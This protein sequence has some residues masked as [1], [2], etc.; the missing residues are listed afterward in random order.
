MRAADRAVFLCLI[1][2]ANNDDCVIPPQFTLSLERISTKT[3]YHVSTVPRSL[4]HLELHRWIQRERS[5]GGRK[6]K[7]GA[8]HRSRYLVRQDRGYDHHSGR[9]RYTSMRLIKHMCEGIGRPASDSPP[10]FGHD[11]G[12]PRHFAYVMPVP[13]SATLTSRPSPRLTYVLRSLTRLWLTGAAARTGLTSTSSAAVVLTHRPVDHSS[14]GG[15][16]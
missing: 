2:R 16:S 14:F 15:V 11:R 7:D 12:G 5:A 9:G 8:N 4:A 1:R 10:A 3:G 13:D 6:R